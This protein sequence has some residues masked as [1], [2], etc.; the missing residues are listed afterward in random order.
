GHLAFYGAYAMINL[1]IITYAMPYLR[2]RQPYNQIL[3]M[4][5]FWLMS[6]GMAFMTFALTVAGVVQTHLQRVL[7]MDYMEVQ[8]QIA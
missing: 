4:W 5:S 7:G 1:A 3:N 8:A 6:G 2:G